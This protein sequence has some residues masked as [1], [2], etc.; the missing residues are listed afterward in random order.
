MGSA[1]YAL[2]N[3]FLDFGF[4]SP[5]IEFCALGLR[6]SLAVWCPQAEIRRYLVPDG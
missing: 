3:R 1:E 2:N 5:G 4:S 6:A